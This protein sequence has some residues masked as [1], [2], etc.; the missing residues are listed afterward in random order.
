MATRTAATARVCGA[1]SGDARNADSANHAVAD[2]DVPDGIK[3][4]LR[5][6]HAAVADDDV[7][8][9]LRLVSFGDA[10]EAGDEDRWNGQNCWRP[11]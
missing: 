10:K 1:G 7:V 2:A 3:V 6:D 11:S 9:V 8:G 4:R 5:I